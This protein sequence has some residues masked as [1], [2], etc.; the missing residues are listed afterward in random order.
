MA[1]PNFIIGGPPK[2]GTTSVF[3]WLD[4][5]PD[6][7]GS[8][9][10]ETY[11]FYDH[12]DAKSPFPNY[13]THGLS[14]YQSYFPDSKNAQIIF[15]ASPGY[16]Y[17]D[18]AR[19]VFS[20]FNP[21][22]KILFLFREPA[23]RMYSEY[24]FNRYKTKKF[25]GSFAEYVGYKDGTFTA[26]R[27]DESNYVLHLQKW[28]D[29]YDQNLIRVLDF[30]FLSQKPQAFMVAL[31]Q[32]LG[33]D[34]DFYL[35]FPFERKNETFGL[36]HRGLHLLALAVKRMLPRYVSETVAPFYYA[37]NKSAIPPKTPEEQDLLVRLKA[38]YQPTV[39]AFQEKFEA[40]YVKG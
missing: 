32:F 16:L 2:S 30:D 10:K 8:T 12:A 33:L 13:N 19:K 37:F 28:I 18:T 21:P 34:P 26:E 9:V 29:T 27:L 3:D 15:E 25:H 31:C 20:A 7:V 36:R 23:A 6:A 24:V 22:P 40:I 5:H 39:D 35:Q 38:F 11:Y 14:S 4:Q 1:L 17:M